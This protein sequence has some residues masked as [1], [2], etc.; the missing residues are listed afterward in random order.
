MLALPLTSL[1]LDVGKRS[2]W[3]SKRPAFAAENC[4]A[5]FDV[6]GESGC[7][8]SGAVVLN[9][10]SIESCCDACGAYSCASWT[11]GHTAASAQFAD[12]NCA[13]MSTALAP[14]AVT[15]HV[16][17][18]SKSPPPPPMPSAT[19]CNADISCDLQSSTSW[20]C[21]HQASAAPT[22]LNNCHLAGPGTAGNS[23]CAC[24]TQACGQTPP[25]PQQPSETQYLMIGD[26][27]SL[28]TKGLVWANLSSRGFEPTH[29][30]GNAASTNLGA[31]CIAAWTAAAQPAGR[32]WGVI[33][34][35]F[36]LHDLAFDVERISVA[37]Y[38][39]Q[40]TAITA[41]LVA[42]QRRD[43]TKL[44]WVTTTPV[45]TA[46]TYSVAGPCNTTSKCLNPPRFIADVQLYNAAAAK[47]VAAANAAGA[48]IATLDLYA[49][50]LAHCGGQPRYKECDGFQLPAN[51]HF[52]AAGY[53]V[54]A[55]ATVAAIIDL[56]A[57]R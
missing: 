4:T 28:G 21:Q 2:R 14:R 32:A 46:P 12:H 43:G 49:L 45:P 25:A 40:L 23:T 57:R 34:Y 15:H 51:V 44:L 56:S 26:S 42:L 52:T 8:G 16:C 55:D 47:V 30:P 6:H 27:V 5:A 20:R 11:F 35:Q 37:Q 19:P 17:G 53:Q 36:G 38:A 31:H 9:V 1:A 33:S 7:A 39:S 3:T 29:S 18:T 13:L 50:V 22:A 41:S 24:H 10:S 54:L 48:T